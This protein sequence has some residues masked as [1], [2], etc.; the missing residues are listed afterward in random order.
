MTVYDFDSVSTGVVDYRITTPDGSH[1]E[2]F[3]RD[4]N[5]EIEAY[6][7]NMIKFRKYQDA[8]VKHVYTMNDI[9]RVFATIQKTDR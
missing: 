3:T 2:T 8:V 4:V 5:Q 1:I 7:I 6:Q 9:I